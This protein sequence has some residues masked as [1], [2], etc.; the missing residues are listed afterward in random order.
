MPKSKKRAN[1]TV[2][3]FH[4]ALSTQSSVGGSWSINLT[5]AVLG[6]RVAQESDVWALFKITQFRFRIRC[7]AGLGVAGMVTSRPNT[8]P[9]NQADVGELLDSVADLGTNVSVWSAWVNVSPVTLAGPFGWYHTRQ[10]TYDITEYVA[11]TLCGWTIG[12]TDTTY[13][14]YQGTIAYR[15]PVP[16]NATPMIAELR[17][18]IRQMEE[19]EAKKAGRDRLMLALA[20]NP[21]KTG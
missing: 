15:D 18:R 19:D 6:G 20:Y 8:L 4:V 14:E 9:S 17:R 2:M 11:A 7:P 13:L 1:S 3:S 16:T 10:G 5:P 12:V 21:S